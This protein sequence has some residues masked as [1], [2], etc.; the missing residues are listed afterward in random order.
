MAS[1]SDIFTEV[2]LNLQDLNNVS[3]AQLEIIFKDL[4]VKEISKL[5]VVNKRFNTVCENESFWRSKVSDDYGIRKKYGDTW[6]E[7]ARIM[8]KYD[9]INLN[10]RWIDGRTY[11]EILNDVLQ[12]GSD[13][14]RGL[15][16]KRLFPYVD[17]N[18]GDALFIRFEL[19]HSEEQFQDFAHQTYNK[20]YTDDELN[21]ML[22]INSE[23]IDIIYT[24]VLTYEGYD[25]HLPGG[26]YFFVHETLSFDSLREMIDPILYVMQFSSFPNNKIDHA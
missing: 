17:N 14:I 5:C 12:N 1:V 24:A 20:S 23:E 16:E 21:D 2:R 3:L 8:D 22:L 15:P 10:K 7:T 6:R 9:M 13:R 11:R 25:K 19:G 18:Y 4:T 26:M